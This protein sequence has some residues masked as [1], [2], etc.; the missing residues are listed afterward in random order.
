MLKVDAY[1]YFQTL[2]PVYKDVCIITIITSFI[3]F[4]Y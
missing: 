4:G 3:L 2:I 1:R